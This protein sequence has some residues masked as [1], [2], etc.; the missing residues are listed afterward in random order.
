MTK[1]KFAFISLVAIIACVLFY[2]VDS[3]FSDKFN[4]NWLFAGLGSVLGVYAI[5]SLI[6]GFKK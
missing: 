5:V 2:Q 3:A 1:E 6:I 4:L